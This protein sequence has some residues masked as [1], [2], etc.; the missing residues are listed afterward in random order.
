MKGRKGALSQT[1]MPT[2][3]PSTYKMKKQIPETQCLPR[4][5]LLHHTALNVQSIHNLALIAFP[6]TSVHTA[7]SISRKPVLPKDWL[8][9]VWAPFLC[10][11][12]HVC[13]HTCT[14]DKM[15]KSSCSFCSYQ[16]EDK[17]FHLPA[18]TLKI[19]IKMLSNASNKAYLPF[20]LLRYSQLLSIDTS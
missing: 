3:L 13:A 19:Q 7:S 12:L 8:V 15:K 1:K 20:L 14:Q 4:W 5:L 18:T 6:V 16:F 17:V 2:V 11:L 9:S 10:F